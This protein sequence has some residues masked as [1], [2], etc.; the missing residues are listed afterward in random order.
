MDDLPNLAIDA[1]TRVDVRAGW[2]PN[3]RL[4][5]SV[6][7]RNLTD[8]EH[9]EFTDFLVLP[10]LVERSAIASVTWSF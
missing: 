1:Y 5:L 8:D 7:V 3:D 4:E 6:A 2:T 9:A 10:V